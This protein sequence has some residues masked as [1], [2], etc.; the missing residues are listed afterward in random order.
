MK[1][2]QKEKQNLVAENTR[3]R[4]ELQDDMNVHTELIKDKQKEV[5][6]FYSTTLEKKI[7]LNQMYELEDKN[8]TMAKQ[9]AD[10]K[11]NQTQVLSFF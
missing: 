3:L 10:L 5:L 6:C 1:T 11:T 2:L 8:E 7:S 4:K 9:I